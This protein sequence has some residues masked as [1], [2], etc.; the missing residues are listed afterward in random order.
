MCNLMVKFVTAWNEKDTSNG[1]LQNV[2]LFLTNETSSNVYVYRTHTSQVQA[3][4]L[5][6]TI[7]QGK[8]T[9]TTDKCCFIA[10]VF[11]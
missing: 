8:Y 3:D 6:E 2:F 1:S 4:L 5:S 10:P 7:I 9:N 11:R